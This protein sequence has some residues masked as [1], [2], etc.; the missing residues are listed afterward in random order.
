MIEVLSKTEA[1]R[2]PNFRLRSDF[3]RNI[4]GGKLAVELGGAR[5]D[6]QG[7]ET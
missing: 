2:D 4:K 3:F 5:F 6:Q 7:N 1:P